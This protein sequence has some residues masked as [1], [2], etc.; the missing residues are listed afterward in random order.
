M[1][2][3]YDAILEWPFHLKVTFSLISEDDQHHFTNVFWPDTRSKCFQR[4][5][6]A[7]NEAYGIEK[8]ISLDEFQQNQDQYVRDDTMFVKIEVDFLSKAPGK[9]IPDSA[10][11]IERKIFIFSI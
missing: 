2:G 3:E 5:R 9:N 7:M 8:F 10:I 1:R 6:L 11:H 4:P